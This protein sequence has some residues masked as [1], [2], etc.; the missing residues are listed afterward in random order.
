MTKA[1]AG[2]VI[3]VAVIGSFLLVAPVIESATSSSSQYF[4]AIGTAEGGAD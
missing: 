1:W 2:V 4:Q 3:V